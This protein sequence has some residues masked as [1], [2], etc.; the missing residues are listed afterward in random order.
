[1]KKLLLACLF[2]IGALSSAQ[3]TL[4]SGTTTGG[5]STSVATVPWSTYYGYSYAQ[6]I[7]TK[8]N[9]NA[10]AA[11][12]ITGLKFYMGASSTIANSNDIVV[13]VGLTNKSTFT[14]TSDWIPTT[15]LTQ[16][17][18][19]TA[20]NNAGVVEITFSAPFAYDNVNNLVIAVDENKAGD[21]GGEFF[22]TYS[23]GA[24]KT[25]YYRNDSTN[26]NPVSI[27][28]TGTRSATQ[29]VVTLLGLNPSVLPACPVPSAPANNAT[30]VSVTPAI[31]WGAISNATGYRISVGTTS[32]GTDVM[33]NVDVGNVVT[34]TLPSALLYG[35]QY[36]YTVNSYN[37]NGTSSGCTQ[38]S[39]T[40]K[41]IGCPSVT[42]PSANAAGVSLTP[43]VTWDAVTDATG[44]RLSVGTVT[45]GTNVLNNIDLG[46]V[47]T[48]TFSTP[49]SSSTKYYYTVN[50]YTA[51][52]TSASCTERNFTTLC[53]GSISTFPWTEN[54]DSMSSVGSG[55]VQTCWSQVT[56][57]TAWSSMNAS[58]TSYNAPKSTPNYMSIPYSNT[59]ASQLWTPGFALTAGTPYEFSFY[60]NTNGTTSS[61]VGFTGDVQVNSSATLTG[62]TALGTFITATQGTAAYTQYKVVYTPSTTG[63]YYFALNV[64]S[65]SAPWY[66]GVDDFKLQ[67]A[68]T[69][70]EP[71]A[72][73]ISNITSNSAAVSWTAPAPSPTG[74][75]DV[76][77]ST[78][79]TPPV[80]TTP[81]NMTGVAGSSATI[82]GLTAGINYYVWVR[83][84]CTTTDQSSWAGP[85]SFA[86][87]PAN[88]ICSGAI[89]LTVGNN[90]STNTL[91]TSN[92]GGTTDG[93]TSCQSARGDNVWFS[94]VVPASGNLTV[95]TKGVTGSGLLDTVLS[96]HSGTCGS[97]TSIGCNDD[98]PAGG[99]YSLVS[100]T[101]QTPGATLYF[102]VWRYTGTI[103]GAS[104]NG[105]FQISAYDSSIVLATNEVKDAKNNIK[106]YPNPFSDVITISDIKNVKN[107]FVSDI[108][109]RLVKTIAN[110]S[111]SLQLG[112]LKQGMYLLTL[113]MKDGS[114]QTIK[115]IKK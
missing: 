72:L 49:L 16:V 106:V 23:N 5:T 111:S 4:G 97:L 67:V 44:Y 7:I 55:I 54:F 93:T 42:A 64:S 91:T 73:A 71:T 110:P 50:S 89:A 26:P 114:K 12:N 77:Y 35:K 53:S 66:L 9:I 59:A 28:Q 69:C 63:N 8:A 2:S 101:G 78:T 68:P 32:G 57:T 83:S 33:N 85:V 65:T 48:Y 74:G 24:D 47:T 18:S 39:F 43:T 46:N 1:M 11:G 113:E 40:T 100:L 92:A 80:S 103:G 76:Y 41:N 22:Y 30:G 95:E 3:I 108:S 19:G 45:G 81:P 13:Y 38:L 58:S 56:G 88:D 70:L 75:Y 87:P 10:V 98:N 94:V 109:G 60:Y 99:V 6:Q 82:P 25:L 52:N 115:T 112:E 107:V 105:A 62:A 102:S 31:T 36:Y 20:T 34:Y 90:F 37:T 29:S 27:T 96:A 14:S 21:D 104:T 79:N 51:N 86:I 17:F 84:H 61:Y 15:S